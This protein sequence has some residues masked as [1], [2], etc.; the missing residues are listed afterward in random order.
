MKMDINNILFLV[1]IGLSAGILSGLVGVG[2]GIIMVPL[3]LIMGFS[4]HQAQ[5]TSLAVLALPVTF[6]AAY[7][8]QKAGHL[9]WKVALVIALFFIVGAY[10]GSKIAINIDQKMLKKIFGFTL[11]ILSL[12]LI[13]SK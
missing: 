3:L 8:Y 10:F 7:N 11:L 4:Q 9:D 2:G 6:I 12:R 1:L 13:F 5:G